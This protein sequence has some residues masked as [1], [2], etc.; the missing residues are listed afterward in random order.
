[1]KD[2]NQNIIISANRSPKKQSFE[3]LYCLPL[4]DKKNQFVGVMPEKALKYFLF[5]LF[6]NI[7]SHLYKR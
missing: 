6:K 4:N 7:E 3:S 2:Q 5:D 1:M